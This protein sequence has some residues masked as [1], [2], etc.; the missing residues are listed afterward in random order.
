M[1]NTRQSHLAMYR[2]AAQFFTMAAA[3]LLGVVWILT[4]VTGHHADAIQ[5]ILLLAT[6]VGGVMMGLLY[7][8]LLSAKR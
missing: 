4:S 1:E 3:I 5:S 8:V 2:T 7:V 6:M